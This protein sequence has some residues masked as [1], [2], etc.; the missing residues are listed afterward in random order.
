[1]Q[2][3]VGDRHH[4]R[5]LLAH[6]LHDP[7]DIRLDLPMRPPQLRLRRCRLLSRQRV[8]LLLLTLYCLI[9]TGTGTGTGSSRRL[10]VA[11]SCCC[12]R[13]FFACS[14]F[15]CGCILWF[16]THI[17]VFGGDLDH[18]FGN[19]RQIVLDFVLDPLGRLLR[20]GDAEVVVHHHVQVHQ[21]VVPQAPAADIF[22]PHDVPVLGQALADVFYLVDDAL[23][24]LCVDEVVHGLP[25]DVH[26]A[27]HDH[28]AHEY[29]PERVDA[30]KPHRR[31]AD[32]AQRH[33]RRERVG[34]VVPSVGDEHLRP[35][36]LAHGHS[37]LVQPLFDG[38]GH[39]GA[40]D[41]R[42]DHRHG[43]DG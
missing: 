11:R 18:D 15:R 39:H 14:S 2:S 28:A 6:I 8:R 38:Y 24:D 41:G 23:V 3:D 13:C 22:Q 34:A 32:P 4:C 37:D 26:A 10:C 9:S 40:A 29:P 7:A 25:A 43:L 21:D 30:R 1:M 35:R 16:G 12:L 27:L 19:F 17:G 31:A 33:D 42:R 5:V 36:L 20:C